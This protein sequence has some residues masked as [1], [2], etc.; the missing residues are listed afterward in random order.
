M[1]PVTYVVD[2]LSADG[3]CRALA[4]C[5][6]L[7]MALAP[8]LALLASKGSLGT[9]VVPVVELAVLSCGDVGPV[10]L[11]ENL[12]VLNR[13]HCAVVVILVDLLV[14][15]SVDFLV[16]VLLDILVGNGGRYRLVDRSVIVSGLRGKVLDRVLDLVHRDLLRVSEDW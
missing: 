4:M 14:D 6:S 5:S 11:R 2:M 3:G 15:G 13:L 9:L 10:L 16:L 1:E 12:S 7:H 8:E